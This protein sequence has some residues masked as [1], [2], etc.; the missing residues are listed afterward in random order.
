MP[1]HRPALP[2][3][4]GLFHE[5]LGRRLP[6]S[7]VPRFCGCVFEFSANCGTRAKILNTGTGILFLF[8]TSK[9]DSSPW[10]TITVRF[11][12]PYFSVS[13]SLNV[14]LTLMIITRLVLHNRGTRTPA[15]A[16]VA[17]TGG[18]YKTI[19]TMLVESSALYAV[20]SLL[21]IGTFASQSFAADLFLPILAEAQVRASP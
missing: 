13:I 12:I 10:E 18:L 2:M 21:V 4:R 7:P 16:L 8:R 6:I 9:L 17:G 20:C 1:I 5:P 14:L 11:S 19:I 15:A 3:L